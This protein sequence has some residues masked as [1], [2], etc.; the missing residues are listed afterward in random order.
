MARDTKLYERIGRSVSKTKK[1]EKFDDLSLEFVNILK[2][3]PTPKR[4]MNA[5]QHMWGYVSEDS[6]KK[7]KEIESLNLQSMLIEIQYLSK[8]H[9]I[10]Y[11]L[12]STSLSEL[13]AWL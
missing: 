3:R 8:K 13:G 4:L 10:K 7:S 9:N 5:L 12:H 11:L 6:S 1:F 2:T